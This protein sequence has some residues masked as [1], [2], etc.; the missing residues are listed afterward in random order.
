MTRDGTFLVE[1]GKIVGPVRNLRYTQ[2]YLDALAGV[3]AVGDTRKTIK[4]FLGGAAIPSVRIE[5]WTFTG[6]TEH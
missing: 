3:T 1:G 5:S 4:G 2:S 6:A